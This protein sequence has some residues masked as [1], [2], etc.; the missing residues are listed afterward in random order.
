MP[1]VPVLPISETWAVKLACEHAANSR[2]TFV[3]FASETHGREVE[4]PGSEESCGR[5]A[6]QQW[7]ETARA[8]ALVM[9][10][11]TCVGCCSTRIAAEVAVKFAL[12]DFDGFARR[13]VQND[14]RK[15]NPWTPNEVKAVLTR[16]LDKKTGVIATHP[17]LT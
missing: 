7:V 15:F 3:A 11:Q 10:G 1:R 4:Y 13:P 2:E 17:G 9:L 16:A 5:T 12:Q 14:D 8:A 6:T